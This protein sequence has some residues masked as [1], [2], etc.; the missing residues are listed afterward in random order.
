MP[1]VIL[2]CMRTA[3]SF[4]CFPFKV[5]R[6]LLAK[7]KTPRILVNRIVCSDVAQIR[8]RHQSWRAGIIH[9]TIVAK[10]VRLVSIN[11]SKF[12]MT[13]NAI[14]LDPVVYFKLQCLKLCQKIHVTEYPFREFLHLAKRHN[15]KHVARN[16][17]MKIAGIVAGT[18][19]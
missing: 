8:N 14:Q 17:V 6:I 16:V 19:P 12:R 7:R 9:Q 3:N 15:R 2:W 4:G 1:N 5:E 13:V 10:S 11:G 18:E